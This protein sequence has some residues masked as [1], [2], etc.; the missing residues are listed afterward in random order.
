MKIQFLNGGLG[1]QLFQYI[2]AR[3]VEIESGENCFL[4]DSFFG[5]TKQHNG[6]EIEKVF[7]NAIPHLLSKE[8]SSSGWNYFMENCGK[9]IGI[10]QS[11]KDSG[12]DIAIVAETYN[13]QFDGN[14]IMLPTNEFIPSI[15]SSQG[16]IYY[17]G[18]WI[19]RNWLYTHFDTIANELTFS[20]I[21]DDRNRRYEQKIL[22]STSVS[23]HI[24]R[25]D[26]VKLY[27]SMPS[28]FYYDAMKNISEL[29]PDATYFVFSDEIDWCKANAEELGFGFANGRVVY[30]E[31]NVKGRN[32]ID[33]QLMSLCHGMIISKS[34]FS[35]LAALLNRD[36]RKIVVNPSTIEI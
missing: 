32:Y 21:N 22:E 33:M 15:A 28:S 1:N 19:N 5:I 16:N 36:E 30:V 4:D 7:P 31:G 25:G 3:F 12:L 14:F 6:Y 24:R 18:Y 35:Y 2:F 27:R 8:F 13:F 9:G 26:F 10:C 29:L 34:A 17:H 11:I 20:K 23:I